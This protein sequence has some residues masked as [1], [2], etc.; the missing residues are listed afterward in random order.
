MTL[1]PLTL[2]GAKQMLKLREQ[3]R[4][5]MR[6]NQPLNE[7]DQEM[8]FYH[9]TQRNAPE[10]WWQIVEP[11]RLEKLQDG[12]LPVMQKTVGYC[13]VEKIDWIGR[14]GEL[15]LLMEGTDEEWFKTFSDLLDRA[16]DELALREVHAE[17]YYCSPDRDRWVL[18]A[19]SYRA[20][21]A[22]LPMRKF[23]RGQVW[24]ADWISIRMPS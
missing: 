7:E 21:V 15:S 4:A 18:V 13:G 9:V 6:T 5:A 11:A 12:M 23:W 20:Q 17:V 1:Q 3:Y 22:T 10:R 2:D 19:D 8:W 24:D 14:T 16:F